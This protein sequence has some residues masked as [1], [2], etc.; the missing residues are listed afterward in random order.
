MRNF[1]ELQLLNN[2]G[3]G[4]LTPQRQYRAGLIIDL[5]ILVSNGVEY[6]PGS[7]TPSVAR[8]PNTSAVP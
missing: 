6:E 1:V 4:T 5:K 8:S 3:G 2:V 7:Q